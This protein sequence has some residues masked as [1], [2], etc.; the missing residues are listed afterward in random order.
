MSRELATS[1]R[2]GINPAVLD[3]LEAFAR[4]QDIKKA[5]TS[6]SLPQAEMPR[7]CASS[8]C[9]GRPW[10]LDGG[11]LPLRRWL[12]K[13]SHSPPRPK[14]WPS[15]DQC[16]SRWTQIAMG[17]SLLTNSKRRWDTRLIL[18]S[19][20]S[21][22]AISLIPPPAAAWACHSQALFRTI[23][24]NESGELDYT[25]FL[26]AGLSSRHVTK[27]SMKAAFAILDRNGDGFITKV[28]ASCSPS[29][30]SSH[31]SLS[32]RA[33]NAVQMAPCSS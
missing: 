32:G 14:S 28:L 4:A 27:P 26:G 5:R 20:T 17:R 25:E 24:I 21:R 15:F 2:G 1:P 11:A 18:Q 31:R 12:S 9:P 8:I 33:T 23:D 29:S 16:S 10:G 30:F 7:R 3:S 6:P 22:I 13:S 19:N